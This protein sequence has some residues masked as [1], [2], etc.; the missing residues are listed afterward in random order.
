[1][2][3]QRNRPNR[4]RMALVVMAGC[5]A[6]VVGGGPAMADIA[7]PTAMAAA[8]DPSWDSTNPITVED[9]SWD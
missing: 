2:G 9:P 8:Q 6:V 5:V 3:E 4:L 1:M 7:A